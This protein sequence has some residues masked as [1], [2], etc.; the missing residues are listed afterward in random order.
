MHGSCGGARSELPVLSAVTIKYSKYLHTFTRLC[1]KP[2]VLILLRQTATAAFVR[3]TCMGLR[4]HIQMAST[5]Q[6][7]I[8]TPTNLAR[9][10]ARAW[11]SVAI[12]RVGCPG[13]RVIT[14]HLPG[15]AFATFTAPAA[16]KSST[17][18]PLRYLP[19]PQQ[20]I[21]WPGPKPFGG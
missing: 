10:S 7:G 4:R 11:W 20:R 16:G 2:R 5:M 8:A 9:P 17:A 15:A 12:P 19:C 1:N 21:V 3:E 6:D 14:F 13:W 18:E